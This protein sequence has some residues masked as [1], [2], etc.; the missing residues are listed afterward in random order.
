MR[1]SVD[2]RRPRCPSYVSDALV[3]EVGEALIDRSAAHETHGL[4][5]ASLAEEALASPQHNRIDRQ[6][7]LIL[8]AYWAGPNNAMR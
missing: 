1:S 6:S 5:V 8:W 4:L 7:H 3:D 2:L